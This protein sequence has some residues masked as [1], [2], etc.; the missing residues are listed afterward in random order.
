MRHY[1]DLGMLNLAAESGN[2]EVVRLL[3]NVQAPA[4]AIITEAIVVVARKWYLDICC[5]EENTPAIPITQV[6]KRVGNETA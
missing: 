4:I 5:S 1:I 6:K 2:V 3:L